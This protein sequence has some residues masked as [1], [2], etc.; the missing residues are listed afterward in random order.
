MQVIACCWSVVEAA[1]AQET[2]HS[3]LVLLRSVFP[4]VRRSLSVSSSTLESRAMPI[5]YK[6]HLLGSIGKEYKN[7]GRAAVLDLELFCLFLLRL[8]LVFLLTQHVHQETAGPTI[9]NTF[10]N[11]IF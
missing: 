7:L 2:E 6:N 9:L 1:A 4:L 10:I 5:P 11:N 8:S 3:E